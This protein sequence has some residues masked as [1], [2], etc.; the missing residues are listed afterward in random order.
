ML[1]ITFIRY[2]GITY[3]YFTEIGAALRTGIPVVF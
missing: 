3:I 1:R 2:A